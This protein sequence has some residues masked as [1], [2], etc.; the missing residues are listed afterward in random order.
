MTR[1]LPWRLSALD[2]KLLRDLWQV[3]GQALAIALVIAAGIAIFASMLSTLD[4]L[5][6]TL[7][8]Y[9][10][11]YR[12]ADVF[13][14]LER[15]PMPA[16]AQIAAIPGVARVE[17]RVVADVTLDVP[18]LV[19]PATGRLISIPEG[20]RP[21]LMIVG[22]FSMDSIGVVMD[23]QANV[24]Q[25]Y[26]VM[27]TFVYPTSAAA[28]DEVRRL[29]GVMAVEPFR[30]IPVRLR[31][32]HRSRHT[33][34]LSA[35]PD[36]R[37]NRIVGGSSRTV[38]VPPGGFLLSGMLAR[39]LGVGPGDR[40]TVEVLEGERRE[41]RIRVAG[42]VDEYMGMNAYM[43]EPAIHGL[44]QEG[45]TL[46][47]VY[48]Q[49]DPSQTRA[50][51]STLKTTPR[52]A[53]VLLKD[54][55]IQNL[56]D[57]I[58]SM[59]RQMLVIYVLFAGT[60]AFG[61]VYNNARISLAE[62]GRELTTLR[63]IG[64][65]RGEVSYILLGELAVVTLAALPVG[66]LMGYAMAASMMSILETELWRLPFV[67]LPR[68]YALAV[69]TSVCATVVSALIVRR[70]IDRLDLVAVLKIRE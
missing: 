53:G 21:A 6:L 47:G 62:R 10:E 29:P 22:A 5:D 52:V 39:V 57:T 59:L 44:M 55:A 65:S 66:C 50:L 33:T 26:D 42:V 30:A 12:F 46:S 19:E 11:R 17:T 69:M 41:V 24:A 58:A 28:L 70:R 23:T 40:V 31:S 4:S 9:Y 61:V 20:G 54:A 48:L 35:S 63:V 68:T 18:D 64:F 38:P 34:I 45:R 3:R 15:A 27:V 1:A 16:A 2:R 51:Y 7:R 13:A 49:V 36:A 25:R 14:S 67:I 43:D 8:T 32:D 60:I 37:L 56:N